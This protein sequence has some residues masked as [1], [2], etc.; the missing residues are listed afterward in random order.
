MFSGKL[1]GGGGGGG[2]GGGE[3]PIMPPHRCLASTTQAGS[4]SNM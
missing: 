1:S 3:R 2:G 4:G